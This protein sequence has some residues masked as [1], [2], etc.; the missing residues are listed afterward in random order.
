[1][2]AHISLHSLTHSSQQDRPQQ[3]FHL[4]KNSEQITLRVLCGSPGPGTEGT[5]TRNCHLVKWDLWSRWK[6]SNM[7]WMDRNW[8]GAIA[9]FCPPLL[10]FTLSQRPADRSMTNFGK[11][12]LIFHLKTIKQS[13]CYSRLEISPQMALALVSLKQAET[14]KHPFTNQK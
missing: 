6:P 13:H 3:D 1:M 12:N 4:D 8:Q 7:W 14:Q 11:L 9:S 5:Q 2:W 10:P